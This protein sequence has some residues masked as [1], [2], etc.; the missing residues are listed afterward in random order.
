MEIT[1][2]SPG[3]ATIE[4]TAKDGSGVKDSLTVYVRQKTVTKIKAAQQSTSRYVKITF[5]KISGAAQYY[6]YRST[7]A[8][9][10][11]KK[12]GSTKKASFV[13]KKAKAAKNYYYK[14]VT[15][16]KVS[17]CNSVLSTKYA[18]VK[19]LARPVLKVKA[20]KGRK[21]DVSW[22]KI[23]GCKGYVIYTSAKKTKGFKTAK[24]LKNAKT[25]K[26]TIK[27]KKSAKKLYVKV[28]PYYTEK[29]KKRYGAYSKAIYIKIKK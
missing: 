11:Y 8:K 4:V 29:G 28:R 17:G 6:I 13:D 27:A 15:R 18:K 14:V 16:A 9:K 23:K 26:A 22:K 1:A 21:I 10:G 24:I 20:K 5:G 7:N 2:K 19:V 12:I 3:K 25:V